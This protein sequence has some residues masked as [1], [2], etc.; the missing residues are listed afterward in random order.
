[1]S[2]FG[3]PLSQRSILRT[4]CYMLC[5]H[6][7]LASWIKHAFFGIQRW[8]VGFFV[9]SQCRN[10]RSVLLHRLCEWHTENGITTWLRYGYADDI[11]GNQA[12]LCFQTRLKN[13]SIWTAI[14]HCHVKP[15][16]LPQLPLE[17]AFHYHQRNQIKTGGTTFVKTCIG[18]AC[19]ISLDVGIRDKFQTL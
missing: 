4:K 11:D 17:I 16:T 6:G 8:G 13:D 12:R 18:E 5:T 10:P 2:Y 14:V 9:H 3:L 19:R 7:N 1:M 15:A